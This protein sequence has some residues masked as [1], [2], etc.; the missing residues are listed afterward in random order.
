MI[1]N[2]KINPPGNVILNDCVWPHVLLLTIKIFKNILNKLNMNTT[3]K[4]V[5]KNIKNNNILNFILDHFDNANSDL[6]LNK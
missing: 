1:T 2:V 3:D 5:L 4:V 6:G